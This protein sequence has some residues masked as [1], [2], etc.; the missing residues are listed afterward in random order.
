M[1]DISNATIKRFAATW[2]GNKNRYEGTSV[3][4]SNIPVDESVGEFIL[5]AML[6]PFTKTSEFFYFHH[7]DGLD[8]H[9]LYDRI[10]HIFNSDSFS[11]EVRSLA[12]MLYDAS[13]NPNIQGGEFFIALFEDVLFNEETVNAIGL[14]KIQTRQ[15]QLRTERTV[16][17]FALSV[18]LGISMHDKMEVGALIFNLD[19]SEGYRVCAI[20]TVSKK[21]DRSFWKDEFLR[22][23]PIEDNYFQTRHNIAAAVEFITHKAPVK[24]GLTRPETIEMANNAAIY[25]KENEYFEVEDFCRFVMGEDERKKDDFQKFRQEYAKAYAIPMED[26]FEISAPAVKKEGGAFKNVIKLDKNF[27]LTVTTGRPDLIERGF[28]EEKGKKYYRVFFD[29]EA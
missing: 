20:D 5:P 2:V 29:E 7:E 3:P 9:R 1:I 4:K 14:W 10:Y 25:F 26:H 18:N 8:N 19:E 23:R 17:S 28:D 24:F 12:D 16:D 21:T 13:G 6:G 27:M 15:Y 11:T 22:V